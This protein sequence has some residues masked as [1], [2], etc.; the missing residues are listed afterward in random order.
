MRFSH[1]EG[2]KPPDGWHPGSKLT[3]ATANYQ[4]RHHQGIAVGRTHRVRRPGATSVTTKEISVGTTV[5]GLFGQMSVRGSSRNL[6]N[7]HQ[8]KSIEC[9]I[10]LTIMDVWQ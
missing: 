2:A 5:A 6:P 1:L 9:L 3:P 10:H 8:K 7:P 4:V